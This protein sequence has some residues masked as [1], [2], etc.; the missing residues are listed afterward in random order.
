MWK[1]LPE[2]EKLLSKI[3]EKNI[4]DHSTGVY[5]ELCKGVGKTFE[6]VPAAATTRLNGDTTSSVILVNVCSLPYDYREQY[7]DDL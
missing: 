1:P 2:K 4:G 3:F 6:A 5:K 7:T